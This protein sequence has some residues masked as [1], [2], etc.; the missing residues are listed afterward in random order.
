MDVRIEIC[1]S[2]SQPDGVLLGEPGEAGRIVSG[3]VEVPSGA[4]ILATGVLKGITAGCATQRS[5]P[6]RFIGVFGGRAAPHISK[7]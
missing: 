5:F 1:V 2:P 7:C 6:E 3:P 4:I